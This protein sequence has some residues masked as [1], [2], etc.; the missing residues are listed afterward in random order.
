MKLDYNNVLYKNKKNIISIIIVSKMK[1]VAQSL[2]DL[3][4]AS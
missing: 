2:T 4:Y 1:D 3:E